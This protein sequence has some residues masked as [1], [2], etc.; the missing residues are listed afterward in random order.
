MIDKLI[1]GRAPI[2]LAQRAAFRTLISDTQAD[3]LGKKTRAADVLDEGV[4]WAV[5]MD[6]ALHKYPGA[7]DGYSPERFTWYLDCLA[8][9]DTAVAAEAARRKRVGAARA[10]AS[11]N[12]ETAAAAR[13]VLASRMQTFAGRRGAE[14]EALAAA[15]GTSDTHDNLAASLAGPRATRRPTSPRAPAPPAPPLRRRPS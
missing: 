6:D 7:L 11:S 10:T 13:D 12:R 8:A 1:A 15:I 9:L 14:R 4:R 2:T 5:R 3:D